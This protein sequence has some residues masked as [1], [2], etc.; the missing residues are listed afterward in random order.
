MG[1]VTTPRLDG[2]F[3]GE[4]EGNNGSRIAAAARWYEQVLSGNRSVIL[5]PGSPHVN[6]GQR[7]L[8]TRVQKA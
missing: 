1:G 3:R 6:G 4:R 5:G 7:E 8:L 2:V